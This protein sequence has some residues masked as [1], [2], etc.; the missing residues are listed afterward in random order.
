MV[1]PDSPHNY[2]GTLGHRPVAVQFHAGS[3]YVALRLLEGYLPI[4]KIKLVH[5]GS[6]L[7]RFEA[8]WHGEVDA[9]LVM[10]PWIALGEKLGCK[11]LCEGH[12]LGAE[13]ASDDMDEATFAAINRA[14]GKAVDLLNADKRRYL[15]YLIDDPRHAAALAK[16][17]GLTPEDFHLPRLRYTKATPYT[18]EIVEDT[19][20]WM[21]R[22]GLIDPKASAADLV[23]NRVAQVATALA[24]DA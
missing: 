12:Y 6:P 15:H 9:C 5:Y 11:A 3:H 20:R 17:G 19:Y 2:P 4:E 21:V 1:R 24:A 8:M 13:N 10:E 16:Y 23:E 14:V 7:Q 18:D 22:W